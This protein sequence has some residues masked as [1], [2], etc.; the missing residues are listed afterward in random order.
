MAI[1]NEGNAIVIIFFQPH[2]QRSHSLE[3]TDKAVALVCISLCL[4]GRR[5]ARVVRSGNN[6]VFTKYGVQQK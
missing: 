1:G 5:V 3:I 4:L 2:G 6:S